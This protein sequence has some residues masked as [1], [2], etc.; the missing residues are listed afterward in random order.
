MHK[1][2]NQKKKNSFQ[3]CD[4]ALTE[5]HAD[6]INLH[7]KLITRFTKPEVGRTK[8]GAGLYAGVEWYLKQ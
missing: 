8:L 6:M 5:S 3:L 7:Y 1:S 4:V 2:T